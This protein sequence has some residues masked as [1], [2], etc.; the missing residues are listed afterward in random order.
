MSFWNTWLSFFKT[1]RITNALNA[2]KAMYRMILILTSLIQKRLGRAYRPESE[3]GLTGE[4]GS[5]L[6][7][8]FMHSE[9]CDDLCVDTCKL[10]V[11][12]D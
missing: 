4:E 10:Y 8:L 9:F 5:Q 11:C 2:Q 3:S 6:I 1:C 7:N 12:D